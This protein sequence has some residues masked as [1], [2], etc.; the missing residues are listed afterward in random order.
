M[1]LEPLFNEKSYPTKETK[2]KKKL[3]V[4]HTHFE[5][6]YDAFRG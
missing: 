4:A 3:F 5:I 1:L 2:G 6:Y